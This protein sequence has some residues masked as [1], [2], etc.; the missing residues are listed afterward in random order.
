M[1]KFT[2]KG[3]NHAFNLRLHQSGLVRDSNDG[4]DWD[5]H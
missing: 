2:K 5:G 3:F 1:I 4:D